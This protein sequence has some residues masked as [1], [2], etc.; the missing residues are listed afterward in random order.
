MLRVPGTLAPFKS[1]SA[2]TY[3]PG[4]TK[5]GIPWWGVTPPLR[6]LGDTALAAEYDVSAIRYLFHHSGN[7][8]IAI[9]GHS[10]G[11]MQ[12]RWALRFWPDTRAMV[13]DMVGISPDNQGASLERWG[14]T[15]LAPV[16]HCPINFLQGA[17]GSH[18]IAAL[19]SGSEMFPGID[20]SVIYSNEDEVVQKQDTPLYGP[21]SYSWQTVQ[22]VCP[23]DVADHITD[24]TVDNVSWALTLDAITHAGP[25][26]VS[27]V[28]KAT[29]NNVLMPGVTS[30]NWAAPLAAFALSIAMAPLDA[31]QAGV[32]PALPC[33]VYLSACG[34]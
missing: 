11:G 31:P 6:Q 34:S 8:K 27:R 13:A 9:V 10:Q 18:F 25:A 24:G 1:Q 29:C 4:L 3:A 22:Q 26:D 7:R 32:E 16:D 2:W 20:Y 33:Y 28:P 12:P 17:T 21:G 23:N 14:C 30:T 19:N 5:E 15:V